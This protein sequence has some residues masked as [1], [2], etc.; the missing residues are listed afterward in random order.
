M[1]R[2]AAL[3]RVG[4]A[5]ASGRQVRRELAS[6]LHALSH[7]EVAEAVF[8][9]LLFCGYPTAINGLRELRE[10]EK[11]APRS[12]PVVTRVAERGRALCARIYGASTPALLRNLR[13]LHPL[14]P[15]W[16]VHEGYGRMLSRGGLTLVERECAAV[17]CLIAQRAWP[18]AEPHLR[19]LA[20]FRVDLRSWLGAL[21]PV[22][23]QRIGKHAM[24]M[25]HARLAGR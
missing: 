9:S 19:A 21:V 12:A 8:Q 1:K 16:V 14:L 22:V 13:N 17:G 3:G 7:D 4:A 10:I 11:R 25:M 20:R 6:A 18:Q 5:L 15:R 24:K 23:G 2:L